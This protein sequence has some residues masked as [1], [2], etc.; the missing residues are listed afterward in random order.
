MVDDSHENFN[1]YEEKAFVTFVN[2][3]NQMPTMQKKKREY[4][5]TMNLEIEK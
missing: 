3:E 2:K 4:S 1:S 5:D